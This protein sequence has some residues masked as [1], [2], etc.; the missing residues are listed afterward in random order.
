MARTREVKALRDAA[1]ML[2]AVAAALRDDR[3]LPAPDDLEAFAG[4]VR[5]IAD[6]ADEEMRRGEWIT[7]EQDED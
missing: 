5:L 6:E 7:G 4:D 3:P 2:E 1:D